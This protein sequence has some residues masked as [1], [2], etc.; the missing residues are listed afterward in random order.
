M[1]HCRMP[2][3]N[4][5]VG[6]LGEGFTRRARLTAV[7][8]NLRL[9]PHADKLVSAGDA[10]QFDGIPIRALVRASCRTSMSSYS[11]ADSSSSSIFR[12]VV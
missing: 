9:R 12:T 10:A 8:L 4:V 2:Q 7:G 1:R 6:R 11:A 3:C 5:A